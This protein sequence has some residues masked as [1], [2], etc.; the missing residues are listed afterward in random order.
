MG[1]RVVVDNFRGVSKTATSSCCVAND[2]WTGESVTSASLTEGISAHLRKVR[3]GDISTPLS[4]TTLTPHPPSP[5]P[6]YTRAQSSSDNRAGD[7]AIGSLK[8][9]SSYMEYDYSSTSRDDEDEDEEE[10]EEIDEEEGVEN[11]KGDA[12]RLGDSMRLPEH[13]ILQRKQR[14]GNS[15]ISSHSSVA[16]RAPLLSANSSLYG[17]AEL[18]K[19]TIRSSISETVLSRKNSNDFITSVH[20]FMVTSMSHIHSISSSRNS[21]SSSRF[22]TR[23]PSMP[24]S[25][26]QFSTSQCPTPGKDGSGTCSPVQHTGHSTPLYSSPFNSPRTSG[27]Y[28]YVC[29][30]GVP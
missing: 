21:V 16:S 4:T 2:D 23:F 17:L 28:V 20:P 10:D 30:K 12:L 26:Q 29:A 25:P 6:P 13:F 3:H 1:D 8:A 27:M 22:P 5:V 14:S 15:S 11:I 19:S 18:L 7:V 9:P 24:T